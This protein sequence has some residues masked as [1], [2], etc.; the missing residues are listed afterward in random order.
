MNQ[1]TSTQKPFFLVAIESKDDAC[2]RALHQWL[3]PHIPNINLL[4]IFDEMQKPNCGLL[5]E[6][7]LSRQPVVITAYVE[8]SRVIRALRPSDTM[9][10]I[11]VDHGIAPFK[12]Y[13]W[14]KALLES[15]Y[16]FAPTEL[17]RTRL[18]E[19]YPEQKQKIF[20]GAYPR[21]YELKDRIKQ[22]ITE[23]QIEAAGVS[24]WHS[25][26]KRQLVVLSWGVKSEALKAMPD[27][28]SIA[29]L[30]HPADARTLGEK[31]FLHAKIVASD[32]KYTPELIGA[33]TH[34]YGD[35]SSLTLEICALDIPV[36]LFLARTLYRD[37]Y[38]VENTIFDPRSPE[39]AII[40]HTNLKLSPQQVMNAA[41][42]S[43]ALSGKTPAK[44][45]LQIPLGMRPKSQDHQGL[46]R[47]LDRTVGARK[48]LNPIKPGEMHRTINSIK[49]IYALYQNVLNRRPDL[50]GLL[51]Y[52][53]RLAGCSAY[54]EG[55][56]DR[57]A[58]MMSVFTNS[59]EAKK[60]RHAAIQEAIAAK[61]SGRS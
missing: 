22:Q 42:L 58:A 1:R 19:L 12:K 48:K 54:D 52:V 49:V 59:S 56:G 23:A 24:Q 27:D 55:W 39:F 18:A 10:T 53:E 20:L 15:D 43:D 3:Q 35:H 45:T 16:Y 60:A 17:L 5:G 40:P 57:I 32:Q 51:H 61:V 26:A 7:L 50:P 47:L 46:F 21:L 30:L 41:E 13:S 14:S 38:D 29:Y 9:I 33:A 34:I 44:A 11:E 25:Q 4:R 28:P 6:L 2:L 8:A 36:Y 37:D 31:L